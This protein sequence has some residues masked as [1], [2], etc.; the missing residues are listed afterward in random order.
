MMFSG[1]RRSWLEWEP[2]TAV[3][4]PASVPGPSASMLRAAGRCWGQRGLCGEPH[5]VSPVRK[6][7]GG[8]APAAESRRL[9]LQHASVAKA[10]K[11]PTLAS[12][13]NSARW[14][15]HADRRLAREGAALR[16]VLPPVLLR[17]VSQIPPK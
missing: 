6:L 17:G 12:E 4:A 8:S 3:R 5:S 7:W 9:Q 16:Q 1:A 2:G 10:H 14:E 11:A 15:A 13:L